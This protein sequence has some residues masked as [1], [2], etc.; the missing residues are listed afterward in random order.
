MPNAEN[1]G[2]L[3]EEGWDHDR[4]QRMIAVENEARTVVQRRVDEGKEPTPYD[5]LADSLYRL[6]A[7]GL[8]DAILAESFTRSLRDSG[9]AVVPLVRDGVPPH[10]PTD[11]LEDGIDL[12]GA[13]GTPYDLVARVDE[14]WR[15][16]FLAGWDARSAAVSDD[17][18]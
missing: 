11:W 15:R 3:A 16:A 2:P 14:L 5:R 1:P 7:D 8:F 9:V 6:I 13:S 12:Y 4:Y 18:S 10:A 17:G